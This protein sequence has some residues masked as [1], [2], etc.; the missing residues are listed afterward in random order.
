MEGAQATD[1]ANRQV[2]QLV[3][4]RFERLLKAGY[5]DAEAAELATRLE[6]SLHVAQGLIERGCPPPL[7]LRILL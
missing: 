2:M 4:W 7:A 6:I 3:A 5:S 1:S